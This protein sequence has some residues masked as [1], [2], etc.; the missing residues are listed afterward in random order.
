MNIFKCYTY[1]FIMGYIVPLGC[2]QKKRWMYFKSNQISMENGVFEEVCR[3]RVWKRWV[4]TDGKMT[5]RS[6]E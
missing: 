5:L 6:G 1:N 4:H 2:W 3:R